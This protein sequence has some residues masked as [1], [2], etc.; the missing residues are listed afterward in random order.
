MEYLN[1]L[2]LNLPNVCVY[3]PLIW[4]KKEN[5]VL[6]TNKDQAEHKL[7]LVQVW[8]I[9]TPNEEGGIIVKLIDLC[10][11]QKGQRATSQQCI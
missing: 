5:R 8:R 4:A 11:V 6:T 9:M 2:F 10:R 3:L 1:M 7:P